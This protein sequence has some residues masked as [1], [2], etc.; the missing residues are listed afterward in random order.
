MNGR[1]VVLGNSLVSRRSL[2]LA[3]AVMIIATLGPAVFSAE[4]PRPNVLFIISDDLNNSLGC[5]DSEIVKTPNIDS[6]AERGVRFERAYCQF[7]LCGPSRN[8]MLTGLYPNSSGILSNGQIF[9]QT[10]PK[11]LSLPHAFRLQGYFAARIGKLYHYNVPKSIGTNGHDDPASWEMELNPA[12]C[13]RLLEEGDIFSLRPGSFGGTLS[14]YASPRGDLLHTDGLLASDAEWVLERCARDRNRPFFLAV[15]FYRPHTPYVAPK[16]YFSG[17][18]KQRMPLVKGVAE[19]QKDLPKDAL[20]SHKREHEQLT[21]DLRQQAKQAYF[22]SITFMDAQVGRVLD[23]LDRLGLADNTIVVFTSDHGYHLGEHGLWQKM[24][25]FEESARVPMIIAAPGM[26]QHG[27]VA[28]TPVGLIDL[29]PTLADLCDVPAPKNLQGQSLVPMLKD[30]DAQGRGWA[31]SQVT[32]GPRK[33]RTMGFTLR[34]PRWRY[35]EW[36][37]A[38]AGREL[39]DHENDP[40]ELTNL[41]DVAEQADRVAELSRQLRAAVADSFPESGKVP[42]L[43]PGT[44]APNITDP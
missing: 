20:G 24:S 14:W 12:G 15:G 39:Y 37:H 35:T 38:R 13:D 42:P 25:L 43:R 3:M 31:L 29:F 33:K 34:T 16:E 19:D 10:I 23:A 30:P 27:S 17:Y 5:Y 36:D 2:T 4:P 18:P 11:Q 32:R 6:L 44:W 22:A 26:G 21:D 41:A 9:R 28:K 7:P 1:S 40:R 8:S